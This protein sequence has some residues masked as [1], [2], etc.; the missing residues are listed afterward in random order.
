M[1]LGWLRV[2]PGSATS[3][4]PTIRLG[5]DRSRRSRSR[6]VTGCS[7]SGGRRN[8]FT[9]RYRQ[10]DADADGPRL[11]DWVSGAAIWLRRAGARRGRRLGRALLHVPRGH[12]PVLATPP[13]GLGG[14]VRAFR[15]RDRARAGR[16]APRDAL[17]ACSLEHHRSAWRFAETRLTGSRAVAAPIRCCVL[18]AACGAR[19]GS[20]RVAVDRRPST[21][22]PPLR[23]DR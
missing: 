1:S 13:S 21:S 20:A 14:R 6:S 4:A 22:S 16:R 8:P 17:T 18:R 10:L 3:T 2:G 15:G 5:A 9:V 12:R 11:V 19:D 23:V 7:A